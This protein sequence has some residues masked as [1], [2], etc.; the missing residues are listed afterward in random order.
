MKILRKMY[1]KS[2]PDPD[3]S[4]VTK[5]GKDPN[6]CGSYSYIKVG[7][8]IEHFVNIAKPVDEKLFWAGEHTMRQYIGCVHAAY[9][10]GINVASEITKTTK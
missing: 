1:G 6:F 3:Y 7:S 2:I 5:W 8:T 4:Y 9:L 10:S